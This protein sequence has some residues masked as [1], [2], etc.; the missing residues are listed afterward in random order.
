MFR[1]NLMKDSWYRHNK[2]F[3]WLSTCYDRPLPLVRTGY[4]GNIGGVL[5]HQKYVGDKL[6]ESWLQTQVI[7]VT[8]LLGMLGRE[9]VLVWYPL[10]TLIMRCNPNG[11]VK[12]NS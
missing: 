12:V 3:T 6:L 11:W 4:E 8:V 10:N 5:E 2:V 1:R 7:L 9:V